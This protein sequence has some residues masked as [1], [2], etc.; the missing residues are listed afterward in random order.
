MLRWTVILVGALALPTSL[1][2]ETPA[3]R[4]ASA[5]PGWVS[6]AAFDAAVDAVAHRKANRFGECATKDVESYALE[7]RPRTLF[8]LATCQYLGGDS[9]AAITTARASIAAGEA[10]GDDELVRTASAHLAAFQTAGAK[11][12]A[13][14]K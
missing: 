4:E 11:A 10:A 1:T 5:P 9:A 8:H 13:E 14:G 3:P 7:A 12:V 6:R 2:A